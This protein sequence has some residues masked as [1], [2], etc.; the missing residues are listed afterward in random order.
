MSHHFVL[1]SSLRQTGVG[2]ALTLVFVSQLALPNA[3]AQRGNTPPATPR[4]ATPPQQPPRRPLQTLAEGLKVARWNP[5][6]RGPLLAL[7]PTKTTPWMLEREPDDHYTPREPAKLLFVPPEDQSLPINA[8]A[9]YFGLKVVRVGSLTVAAPKEMVVLNTKLPAPD[10]YQ[11]MPAEMKSMLLQSTLTEAQWKQMA[12]P[13]GLGADSM[14]KEQQELFFALLPNPFRFTQM[15]RMENGE[16][17]TMLGPPTPPQIGPNGRPVFQDP[18]TTLSEAQRR[19]ARIR[20]NRRTS[21]QLPAPPG[22]NRGGIYVN[23]EPSNQTTKNQL[24]YNSWSDREE[25]FGVKVSDKVPSKLKPGQVDFDAPQLDAAVSLKDAKVLGDLIQRIREATRIEIYADGRVAGREIGGLGLESAGSVRAGDLLK[26]L[27]WLVSGAVRRVGPV[28]LLTEDVV[29]L[30][31]RKAYIADWAAV[32]ESVRQSRQFQA[33][34]ELQKKPK[35]TLI[36]FAPNDPYALGSEMMLQIEETWKSPRKRYEGLQ[37][38]PAELPAEYQQSIQK[39]IQRHEQQG[40]AVQNPVLTDRA[41]ISIQV[42]MTVIVP[43]VGEIDANSLGFNSMESLLPMPPVS[44]FDEDKRPS[45]EPVVVPGEMKQGGVLYLSPTT[46]EE[47]RQMVRAAGRRGMRQVWVT[48][49][50]EHEPFLPVLKAAVE[51]GKQEKVAVVA[52]LSLVLAP[53]LKKD[54]SPEEREAHDINILGETQSEM[55]KRLSSLAPGNTGETGELPVDFFWQATILSQLKPVD[56]LRPDAPLTAAFLKQ[57]VLSI[58]KIPGLAGIVLKDLLPTGYETADRNFNSLNSMDFGYSLDHRVAMIREEG[59]DPIDL[60]AGGGNS[61]S[62]IRVSIPLF[63]V[64]PQRWVQIANGEYGPDPNYKSPVQSWNKRRF[65]IGRKMLTDVFRL[66][67]PELPKDFPLIIA[68]IGSGS[69]W[70]GTWDEGE[71]IPMRQTPEWMTPPG[72]GQPQK[73]IDIARK[74]SQTVYLPVAV[75]WW[76]LDP[77]AFIKRF[78]PPEMG[79]PQFLSMRINAAIE[80]EKKRG[81][82]MW[83]GMVIDLSAISFEKGLEMFQG[84]VATTTATATAQTP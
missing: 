28:L 25:G 3:H 21:V 63:D 57:S 8:V 34:L 55:L 66:V 6:Q 82:P 32:G 15:K 30:G 67:R 73:T 20:L 78:M 26:G 33:M 84:A 27:C 52:V 42:Q 7:Q 2:V 12:S 65:E 44:F 54:A 17:W 51:A 19:Q 74:F 49:P 59:F 71:K 23:L 18:R 13:Q 76:E 39:A 1:P 61:I 60:G 79:T 58:A 70:F 47:A 35:I 64:E 31:T 50:V 45:A 22:S 62:R 41:N 75:T 69:G 72:G 77:P 43:G 68:G 4:Q 83:D 11:D 36:D 37:V 40:Q 29:G 5:E 14:T 81:G 46:E 48:V 16:D 53:P 38:R 9:D 10:P 24:Q 56:F 80:A